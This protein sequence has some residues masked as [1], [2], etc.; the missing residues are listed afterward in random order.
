MEKYKV[1]V[2]SLIDHIKTATDVDPWAQE[3][4]EDLLKR[5][6]P[7]EPGCEIVSENLCVYMCPTCHRSYLHR[8]QKYCGTCGQALKQE[9]R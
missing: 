7:V 8:K 2:Q 3:M 4:A 5:H 6:E 1:S 9:G